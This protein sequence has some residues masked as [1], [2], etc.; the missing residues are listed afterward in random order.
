MKIV[1]DTNIIVSG[2]L[3]PKGIPAEIISLVL[4]KKLILCYD[5][6]ILSEYTE[7]LTRS[8][9]DF[10]IESVNRFLEF[11]KSN[12]EYIVAETQKTKFIDDDDKKFYDV[13]KSSEAE[14]I[15]TG[16]MKHYPNKKNIITPREFKE[17]NIILR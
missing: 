10:D 5:N 14:F 3:N 16:N 11:V 1:L 4:N 17:L 15:I 7:V 8:K 13:F 6:K 2:F 12:G 9:F